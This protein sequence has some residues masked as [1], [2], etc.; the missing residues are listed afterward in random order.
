MSSKKKYKMKTGW[1][2]V[3]EHWQPRAHISKNVEAD[4]EI[5]AVF[6][7]KPH[8]LSLSNYILTLKLHC[9]WHLA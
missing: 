1:G 8:I 7:N 5:G 9:H 4:F 2:K 6:L 3:R